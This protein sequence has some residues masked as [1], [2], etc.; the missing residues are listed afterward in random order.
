MRWERLKTYDCPDSIDESFELEFVKGAEEHVYWICPRL[1]EAEKE[2]VSALQVKLGASRIVIYEYENSKLKDE[3]HFFSLEKDSS[4]IDIQLVTEGE[5]VTFDSLLVVDYAAYN[6]NYE[7]PDKFENARFIEGIND[8]KLKELKKNIESRQAVQLS[9]FDNK[10]IKRDKASNEDEAL[11]VANLVTLSESSNP[12]KKYLTKMDF[13]LQE[14]QDRICKVDIHSTGTKTEVIHIDISSAFDI[15]GKPSGEVADRLMLRWKVFGEDEIIKNDYRK[16]HADLENIK[17]SYC[18]TTDSNE[19]YI[20][21]KNKPLF[22]RDMNR[23]RTR[24]KL[25]TAN[26]IKEKIEDSKAALI[27]LVRNI[28]GFARLNKDSLKACSNMELEGIVENLRQG[29]PT[30]DEV[31]EKCDV[32]IEYSSIEKSDILNKEFCS[33]LLDAVGNSDR[34]LEHLMQ[35]IIK[36]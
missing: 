11:E 24:L 1:T 17:N 29:F 30:V 4:R 20:L 22:E 12:V 34:E 8:V 2:A 18:I 6:Y 16:I 10:Q 31:I 5:G 35:D 26:I 33:R 3:G 25:K 19:K 15:V 14:I 36:I 28:Y 21:E 9:F 7:D 27:D 13:K 23:F 32:M